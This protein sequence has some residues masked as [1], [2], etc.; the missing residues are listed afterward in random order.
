MRTPDPHIG[1]RTD[2]RHPSPSTVPSFARR[3]IRFLVVL[4]TLALA[5]TASATDA[6]SEF[7][8][9]ATIQAAPGDALYRLRLPAVV[10]THSAHADLRDLRVF[11]GRGETVPH[12]LQPAASAAGPETRARVPVFPVPTAR[13]D[14]GVEGFQVEMR[15]GGTVIRVL[16]ADGNAANRGFSWLADASAVSRPFDHLDLELADSAESTLAHVD[17]RVSEDMKSW[18]TV[19]EAATVVS[20]RVGADSLQRLRIDTPG[21]RGRYVLLIAL[22]NG[23]PLPLKGVHAVLA[24]GKPEHPFESVVFDASGTDRA[25]ASWEYDLGRALPV[26]EVAL[27]VPDGNVLLPVE[28]ASRNDAS[29]PWRPLTTATAYSLRQGGVS[30]YSAPIP[31]AGPPARFFRVRLVSGQGTMPQEAPKLTIRWRS[32]D[33][34]FAARGAPPFTLAFGKGDARDGAMPVASLIPGFG[35]PTAL[36]PT[37]ASLGQIRE[38]AGVAALKTPL[39]FGRWALWGLLGLGTAM[40]VSMAIRLARGAGAPP[41]QP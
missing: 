15:T 3:A 33:L 13:N 7:A 41:P 29:A 23:T 11:N 27:G 5:A 12:A 34:I 19:A 36:E 9:A 14:G 20:T 22:A 18:R 6:P 8:Y 16:G 2:L 31:V 28:I 40:L 38:H 37:R 30:Y 21:A 4:W 35:T 32:D 26:Q 24:P 17:V 1:H 39:P 25:S 10:Y